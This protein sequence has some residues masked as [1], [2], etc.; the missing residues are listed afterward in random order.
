MGDTRSTGVPAGVP[1]GVL[2]TITMDGAMVA[3]SLLGGSAFFSDVSV[4]T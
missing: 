2:A 4:W 1:A 3:A